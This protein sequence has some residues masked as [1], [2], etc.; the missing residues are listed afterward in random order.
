MAKP[1][2]A[3]TPE[4][5]A[6]IRAQNQ[7]W[8]GTP[9]GAWNHT[10][11]QTPSAAPAACF[12]SA[13]TAAA[14]LES[15]ACGNNRP[16]LV[17]RVVLT[18]ATE[19][20]DDDLGP[21][22]G[23]KRAQSHATP[24]SA[25]VRRTAGTGHRPEGR[26][27]AC[28]AKF[29]FRC[30]YREAHD[31]SVQEANAAWDSLDEAAQK[32]Y[33]NAA[34]KEAADIK[35]RKSRH[36]PTEGA[37]NRHPAS[38]AAAAAAQEKQDR[39]KVRSVLDKVIDTVVATTEHAEDVTSN[40]WQDTSPADIARR[41]GTV[42]DE[43][44]SYYMQLLAPSKREI[45]DLAFRMVYALVMHGRLKRKYIPAEY[46]LIVSRL[47]RC[48][49]RLCAEAIF[50]ACAWTHEQ[51]CLVMHSPELVRTEIGA[52]ARRAFEAN[53]RVVFSTGNVN[54]VRTAR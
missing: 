52:G 16:P 20:D 28:S 2:N 38:T 11:A 47:L 54:D 50:R 4:R 23:S 3:G 8:Y 29:I 13:A 39:K 10:V 33:V 15:N 27:R 22:P 19:S 46:T 43:R 9:L 31:V 36:A 48:H 1:R 40:N 7:A 24:A 49:P 14:G 30:E 53:M 12:S 34:A 35:A 45:Y 32:P 37:R 51:C 41:A 21:R 44:C 5:Q 26:R 42:G 25:P 18:L 17:A 6:R